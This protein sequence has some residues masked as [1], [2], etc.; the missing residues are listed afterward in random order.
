LYVRRL[1]SL[2]KPVATNAHQ[3]VFLP[4]TLRAISHQL[5]SAGSDVQQLPPSRDR[6]PVMYLHQEQQYCIHL[7]QDVGLDQLLV[8]ING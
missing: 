8:R 4:G 1:D 3:P 6:A 2:G 5:Q 7:V